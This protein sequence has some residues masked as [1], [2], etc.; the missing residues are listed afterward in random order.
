MH[1]PYVKRCQFRV[2]A[3]EN[4]NAAA[5]VFLINHVWSFESVEQASEHVHDKTIKGLI[6]HI[7]QIFDLNVDNLE[8]GS[9]STRIQDKIMNNLVNFAYPHTIRSGELE[10]THYSVYDELGS[11]LQF[12]ESED[13]A[14]V[15]FVTIFELWGQRFLSSKCISTHFG[16]AKELYFFKEPNILASDIS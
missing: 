4:L 2:V 6:P 5:D 8:T 9:S 1:S 12:S 16:R 11:R 3:K 15:E 10:M 14:N 13:T 7:V